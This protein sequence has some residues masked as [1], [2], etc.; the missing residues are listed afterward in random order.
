MSAWRNAKTLKQLMLDF[1]YVAETIA[2]RAGSNP[3]ALT[4]LPAVS[5]PTD[6]RSSFGSLPKI[7]GEAQRG[8]SLEPDQK[9][10]GSVAAAGN[11]LTEWRK[12][13]LAGGVS[14]GSKS[15][16]GTIAGIESCLGHLLA[17]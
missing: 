4:N 5:V 8:N 15:S 3:V 2:S 12:K 11:L 16:K 10:G 14:L 17:K 6:G 13:T 1:G 9:A 7:R